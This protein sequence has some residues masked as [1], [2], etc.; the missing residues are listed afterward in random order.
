MCATITRQGRSRVIRAMEDNIGNTCS[1]LQA[2]FHMPC[3]KAVLDSGKRTCGPEEC[4]WC[5]LR[6]T[7]QARDRGGADSAV[8]G[9]VASVAQPI[10]LG[11]GGGRQ[12]ASFCASA[13]RH[14][15]GAAGLV[16]MLLTVF[17]G[18][19]SSS[20]NFLNNVKRTSNK[21]TILSVRVHI[22]QACAGAAVLHPR[23]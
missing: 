10:P 12:R 13:E 9:G 15:V 16:Q 23:A 18:L 8:H 20:F 21:R 2:L 22:R 7:L 17:C 3:V 11:C 1:M 4:A 14:I 6:Q 5:L 19:S